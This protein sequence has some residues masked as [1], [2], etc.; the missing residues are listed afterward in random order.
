MFFRFAVMVTA[1]LALAI[2]GE[3][4]SAAPL[5]VGVA[6]PDFT[7]QGNDNKDFKL[8][9]Q[10][11]KRPIVLFFYPKDNTPGCAKE[12]CSVRDAFPEL[13]KLD[14]TVVGMSYD[15]IKSHESFAAK[16]SLP[17]PLLSDPKGDVAKLYGAYRRLFA[18]R[19]TF[20]VGLDGKIAYVNGDVTP[21]GHGQELV[22]VLTGLA[23]ASPWRKAGYE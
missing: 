22:R 7:A 2:L 16:H 13:R 8:S 21:E 9:D 5:K 14:V 19:M 15:S 4:A 12:V 3:W 18:H 10:V 1:V 23:A 20:I 6:A 17:Y 11:G